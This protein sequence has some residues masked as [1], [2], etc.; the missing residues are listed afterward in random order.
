[1]GVNLN[2]KGGLA[3]NT[4]AHYAAQLNKVEALDAL[5]E[6]RAAA[7]CRVSAFAVPCPV[8]CVSTSMPWTLLVT[9]RLLKRSGA[10]R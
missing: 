5:A 3:L 4:P 9:P 7:S 6:A 2:T 8:R 1:M 10:G